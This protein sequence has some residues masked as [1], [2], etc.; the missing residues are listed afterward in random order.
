MSKHPELT[1]TFLYSLTSNFC[2]KLNNPIDTEISGAIYCLNTSYTYLKLF[3][4]D[5]IRHLYNNSFRYNNSTNGKKF[6]KYSVIGATGLAS[7]LSHLISY[8]GG[9]LFS[10][11]IVHLY[12]ICSKQK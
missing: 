8:T 4:R 3:N 1:I 10:Y 11:P 6:V 9:Y 12:N 2:S 7:V 5:D